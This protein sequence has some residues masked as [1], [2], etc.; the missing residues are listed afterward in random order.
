MGEK[1]GEKR[2]AETELSSQPHKKA[3]SP[4]R[5]AGQKAIVTGGGSGMGR[6]I[7]LAFA[8]EGADVVICGRRADALEQ[9]VAAA[10]DLEGTVTA[11]ACD[12]SDVTAAAKLVESAHSKLGRID[13]LV[14]NAGTNIP[15]RKLKDLSVEDFHKVI[16]INLAGMFHFCHSVLPI[17]RAQAC[18]TVLNVSSIAGL[19]ASVLAGSSYCASKY[20]LNALGNTIN[21]EESQNGIRCTNICPGETAT[22]ILDKREHPPPAEVR[23]KMVQPEDMGEVAVMAASLPPRVIIPH[24][25]ITGTTTIDLA[26]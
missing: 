11:M 24:M 1:R 7:A 19:R 25:S 22:E 14:N 4:L 10:A 26:M 15:Q 9:T 13:I 12:Q 17:M 2:C 21:L 20:G 6:G 18:G 8:A 3:H 23:A 5:L 16:D